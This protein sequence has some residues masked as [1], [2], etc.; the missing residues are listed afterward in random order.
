MKC[1]LIQYPDKHMILRIELMMDKILRIK[2]YIKMNLQVKHITNL[3][4]KQTFIIPNGL[5]IK[6]LIGIIPIMDMM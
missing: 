6:S 4:L 1:C 2:Q 5:V 3:E